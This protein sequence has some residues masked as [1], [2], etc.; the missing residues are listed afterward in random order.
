MKPPADRSAPGIS[1][2]ELLVGIAVFT[3]LGGLLSGLVINMLR[4]GTGTTNRLS[5]VDQL[6]VAV[7]AISKGLRTA[8]RPEQ[9][10]PGCTGAGCGEP[11]VAATSAS[12]TFFANYGQQSG[13]PGPVA[14]V[15]RL[16]TYRVEPNPCVASTTARLVEVQAAATQPTGNATAPATI[17][18]CQ[19]GPGARTL[20]TGLPL[21]GSPIFT[22]A[23]SACST[24]LPVAASDPAGPG[25]VD[26]T[27]VAC[28]AINI[29]IVGARD[30]PGT[31]VSTTVFLPNSAMGR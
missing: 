15:A 28:V 24:F 21:P 8:V 19:T 17:S 6:R 18:T 5:N 25:E 14:P 3:V 13:P 22:Y 20:A 27:D 4:T 10:N 23:R 2:V 29:P 16:T 30:N 1:L 26:R 31:S 11:V 7:D 9:L 12:I